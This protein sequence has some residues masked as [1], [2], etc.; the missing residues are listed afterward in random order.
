MK[1]ALNIL[2]GV[3]LA[4]TV[5]CL[6]YAIAT[7]GSNAAINLNLIWGYFLLVFAIASAVFCAVVGMIK[8]P[9]GIKGAIVSIVLILAVIGVSYFVANGHN[10]EIIDLQNNSI[11]DRPST[12]I[13]DTCINVAVWFAIPAALVVALVTEIWSLFK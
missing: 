12:V 13:A 7:G 6:G 1:K 2:L 10:Y 4:I 5:V 8:S 9:T 11:F 3:L